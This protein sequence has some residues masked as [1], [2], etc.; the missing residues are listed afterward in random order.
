M[1][2][3]FCV[4]PSL[5]KLKESEGFG[6]WLIIEVNEKRIV[7]AACYIVQALSALFASVTYAVKS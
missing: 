6:A 2:I 4:K 5:E 3:K 1:G 7:W